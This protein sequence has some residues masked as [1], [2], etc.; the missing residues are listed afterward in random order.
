MNIWEA[1]KRGRL[2]EVRQGLQA[3]GAPSP[4]RL[5]AAATQD[6]HAIRKTSGHVDLVR[7]LLDEGASAISENVYQA[8]RGGHAVMVDMLLENMESVDL[9]SAAAAGRTRRVESI[10]KSAPDVCDLRDEEGKTALHYCCASSLAKTD[11]TASVRLRDV[12]ERLIDAGCHTNAAATCG[13]LEDVTPLT[14]ICWTGGDMQLFELLLHRGAEATPRSLWAA[15]GHFQRH[16]DGHYEL[17]GRLLRLG[18]DIN[19]N[20]WNQNGGRTLLHAFSAHEDELG[21]RWLLEHGADVHARDRDECTPLH[22]AAGRN[23]GTKVLEQLLAAGAV[24][25]VEDDHGQTPIDLAR[26]KR[27]SKTVEFLELHGE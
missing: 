23:I 7:L 18:L 13:G 9:H 8:A 4:D 1:A 11:D 27:R 5:L 6:F 10:L 3:E 17:A 21:V 22:S 15:L 2:E 24:G 26:D 14:H 20:E 16:G 12:A 19:H 25:D